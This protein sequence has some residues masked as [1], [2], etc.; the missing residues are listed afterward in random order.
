M[1]RSSCG[2]RER[3]R[4]CRGIGS[5]NGLVVIGTRIASFE[6]PG[7]VFERR[8]G[9]RFTITYGELLSVERLPQS[10][11]LRLHTRTTEPVRVLC[12]ARDRL[13]LENELRS[14]GVRVV[15]E[16]GAMITPTLEDF[17]AELANGP[18]D[19]RQSSDDA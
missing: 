14:R 6:G 15:D 3:G 19:V 10:W 8:W 12:R 2:H 5:H 18:L 13:S 4:G 1:W 7:L 9:R 16:Y 17:E 11:A